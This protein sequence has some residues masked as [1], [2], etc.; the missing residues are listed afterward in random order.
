MKRKCEKKRKGKE[1]L[2][3]LFLSPF[4][5]VLVSALSLIP[6]SRAEKEKERRRD[7][8][9]MHSMHD[10]STGKKDRSSL[11]LA[12]SLSQKNRTEKGLS[13]ARKL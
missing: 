6:G 11:V 8:G 2:Y 9:A 5:F 10:N 7:G 1:E 3:N 4:F 13:G 12:L